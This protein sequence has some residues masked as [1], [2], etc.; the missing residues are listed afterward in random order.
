MQ[1]FL[2]HTILFSIKAFF[3]QLFNLCSNHKL[4]RKWMFPPSSLQAAEEVLDSVSGVQVE[5]TIFL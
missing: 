1:F 5:V 2:I 4:N 3:F